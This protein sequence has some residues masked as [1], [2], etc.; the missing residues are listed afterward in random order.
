MQRRRLP[1]PPLALA[2]PAGRVREGIALLAEVQGVSP[3]CP[4]N[5][6]LGGS[7]GKKNAHVCGAGG[8]RAGAPASR[9]PRACHNPLRLL[10][11]TC[12]PA[13]ATSPPSSTAP[14]HRQHPPESAGR[15]SPSLPG[16]KGCPLISQE[17]LCSAGR[18]G[19]MNAKFP[20]A[21]AGRSGLPAAR[22]HGAT[23]PFDFSLRPAILLMQRRRL[24]RPPLTLATPAGRVQRRRRKGDRPPCRGSKACPLD[25]PRTLLGGS[26]GKKNANVPGSGSG[27]AGR[28]A[29]RVRPVPQ[30]SGRGAELWNFNQ[31]DRPFGNRDKTFSANNRSIKAPGPE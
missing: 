10:P 25:L 4:K 17:R 27:R 18:V 22:A 7:G 1:P 23:T 21:A 24:T 5:L 6:L 3:A 9:T 8:R 26:G 13:H 28:Q 2:T 29:P 11:P 15:A 16:S 14:Y 30:P 19:R 31:T 20:R 12:Y